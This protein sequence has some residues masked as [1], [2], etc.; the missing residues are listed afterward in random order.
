MN[1]LNHWDWRGNIRELE[2]IIERAVISSRGQHLSIEMPAKTP[3][4][5]GSV[6][7]LKEHERE[8]ILKTLNDTFWKIDGPN[9]AAQQLGL[10]PSTLRHRMKKLRISRPSASI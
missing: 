8:L 7:T 5:T 2:N 9:G 10:N 4:S 3:I 6:K 1:Q